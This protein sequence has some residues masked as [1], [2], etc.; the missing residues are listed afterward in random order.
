MK[1]LLRFLAGT[2]LMV[3]TLRPKI[4]PHTKQTTFDIDTYV[5]SDRA[6]C[7]T[8]RRST[9]GMVLYFLGTLITSE[10]RTQ[11]TVA[12]A[13]GEAE[14]YAIG[15]GVSE[16]LFIRSLL[17]E[18]RLSMNV[19]IRIHTDSTAGKPMATRFGTSKKTKHV[20]LRF[21]FIQEL[22]ASG[23]VSVKKVSGTSNPS[24]VM[25]KYITKEIL[26]RHLMSHLGS[27]MAEWS[28]FALHVY[29]IVSHFIRTH[30]RMYAY[31][32]HRTPRNCLKA[33]G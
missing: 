24:G 22:V 9:S 12:L 27:P 7:A 5:D 1:T 28:D 21:L 3:L 6:G 23:V 29:I 11:A 17:L 25:T 19:N 33:F 26:Q 31:V 4:I 13:S 32:F 20:Q 30:L 15:L 10:S 2:K 18:S 8:S 16:S 14:L